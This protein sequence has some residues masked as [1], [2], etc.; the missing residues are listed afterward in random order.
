MQREISYPDEGNLELALSYLRES[1]PRKERDLFLAQ[2]RPLAQALS[3]FETTGL[4]SF[5]SLIGTTLYHQLR[6]VR[7]APLEAYLVFGDCYEL[8]DTPVEEKSI[9]LEK[10]MREYREYHDFR[11][12]VLKTLR[13]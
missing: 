7:N 9:L 8:V 3:R 4:D 13:E 2:A 10:G 5:L 11:E 1:L 6:R 12:D